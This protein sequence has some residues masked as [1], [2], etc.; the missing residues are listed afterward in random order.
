MSNRLVA[1]TTATLALLILTVGGAAAQETEHRQIITMQNWH[2]YEQYMPEGLKAL[3]SGQYFWKFPSDFQMVV[4]PSTHYQNPAR[5]E[6]DTEKYSHDVKIVNLADGGHNISG[7]VA[8]LPFPSP[9]E[10]LRGWKLLIDDWYAYEPF[11]LCGPS[12]WA[13]SED[14]F[15]NL[16]SV[17]QIW[18]EGRLSHLSDPGY[19]RTIPGTQGDFLAE[20]TQL[21][22]PEQAKYTTVLTMY[23]DNLAK[24]ED[25]FVFIPAL[26]RS[27]RVSTAA[28]CAP[29]NGTDWTYDDTHRGAFNGNATR[30]DADYLG[31][32]K[33]LES[34]DVTPELKPLL[35]FNNYYPKV[36]F[37]KPDL[38]SWQIRDTWVINVHP[39]AA[40]AKGYC[41][42]KR[43][44]YIDKESYLSQWADLYDAGDKL[45]KADYDP[46]GMVDVPGVGP[47]WQNTGWGV[48][49]DLQNA[50]MSMV[51]LNFV[52][53]QDCQNLHG[54]DYTNVSHFLGLSALAQVMR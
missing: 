13:W 41:Y 7:Y 54:V 44:L 21:A 33:I 19:P 49:Y 38:E 42:G 14:R 28:R 48:N 11:V 12:G 10:P 31:E 8:G 20:Y 52:A 43:I 27:L 30:F 51:V 46:Q 3:F 26:R 17:Q 53:N 50:H 23:Y 4:K 35:D 24:P 25:L 40:Y 9:R 16:H 32:K 45:W 15:Y 1:A 36:L 6:E 39:I 5:Y 37:G 29:F 47:T 22:A 2:Q 18:V 34:L